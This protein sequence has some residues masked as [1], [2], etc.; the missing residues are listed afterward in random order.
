MSLESFISDPFKNSHKIYDR[1]FLKMTPAPEYASGEVILASLYRKVG[2]QSEKSENSIS[3]REVPSFGRRF[4]K[5]LTAEDRENLGKSPS[6]MPENVWR[7]LVENTLRSPLQPNQSAKKLMQ[8]TPLVPDA[9]IYSLSAR[10]TGNP[11]DPGRLIIRML[12]NSGFPSGHLDAIW[13]K[14]FRALSVT[15]D[16]DIWARFLQQEFESWRP[17]D[18]TATWS[19][20]EP[21]STLNSEGC[22]NESSLDIPAKRF[23][24]D[25]ESIINLKDHLT[26][27]Q[28]VTMMESIL[29]IGSASHVLWICSAN[30]NV[31]KLMESALFKGDAASF[32]SV[33]SALEMNEPFWRYGT[34]ATAS[35]KRSSREYLKARIGINLI[36]HQLACKIDI[37]EF[38]GGLSSASDIE[39]LLQ[40][41][42]SK[43]IQ[44]KFSF[45]EYTQTCENIFAS[46]NS[47]LLGKR[48]ITSN[49][50][51]FLNYSL[52][53]RQTNE[54][55]LESYDQGYFLAKSGNYR[56]APWTISLGPVSVMCLVH[57]CTHSARGPR[58]LNNF[59]QHLAS[60]GIET[61][62][63]DISNSALGHTMRS[64]GLVL[65]S[66][67]AEGGIALINPFDYTGTKSRNT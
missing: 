65:D 64:L 44:T 39:K 61:D 32:S 27:K 46:N 34:K 9:C 38:Q 53:Q 16:D 28:W 13:Q 67:D 11:W 45:E 31:L 25:L 33:C 5:Q 40:W 43:Q 20:P 8:L 26:R 60:Y 36:L 42:S 52:S 56:S 54:K 1:G 7:R 24:H 12:Q 29:R 19:Q 2:F 41:L 14:L 57:A 55:G 15:K 47:I 17:Q 10:Y 35:I 51:E 4:Q 18:F 62:P 49:I 66:P 50:N 30:E 48:G 59:C 58:T 37:S 63:D 6:E 21:L 22:L 3:E 23:T